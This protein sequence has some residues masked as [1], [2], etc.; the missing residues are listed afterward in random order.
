MTGPLTGMSRNMV[1]RRHLEGANF[2]LEVNTE[3]VPEPGQY[4][5]L[6]EGAVVLRTSDAGSAETAY[7][8]LC[9][10]F[11]ESRLESQD[12]RV[13][14]MSALGL[15]GQDPDHQAAGAVIRAE[16]S[17]ADQ[18]RVQRAS[19]ARRHQGRVS[20]ETARPSRSR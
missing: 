2:S 6:S 1:Y 3:N 20:Q 12:P 13:R 14:R 4:F 10:A 16:G 15:L 8:E 19:S 7:Q 9:H 17:A 18:A 5:V 11:W